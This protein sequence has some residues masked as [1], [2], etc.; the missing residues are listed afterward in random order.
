KVGD[1]GLVS[2]SPRAIERVL[3]AI[4]GRAP[5]LADAPDF[6]YMRARDPAPR[7]FYAFLSDRLIQSVVG[8]AQKIQAAR[9]EVALAELL[10]PGYAALLHGWIHGRSPASVAELIDGGFLAKDELRHR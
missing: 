10:T 4:A 9:R 3:D 8:P 5:R 1:L 7:D 6:Q 2:N